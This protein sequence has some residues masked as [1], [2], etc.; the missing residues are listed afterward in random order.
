MAEIDRDKLKALALDSRNGVK[1]ISAALGMSDATFYLTLDREPELKKVYQDARDEMRAN[2]NPP[3]KKQRAT[4]AMKTSAKRVGGK[5]KSIAPPPQRQCHRRRESR[6][7][8][9]A[10]SGI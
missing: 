2:R 1:E 5:Q 6:A 9:Q 8:T 3:G 4:G 10:D 7:A